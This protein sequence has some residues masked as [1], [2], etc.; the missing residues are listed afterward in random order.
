MRYTAS[1]D[2]GDLFRAKPRHSNLLGLVDDAIACFYAHVAP[3]FVVSVAT[4]RGAGAS[5]VILI[6]ESAACLA[7]SMSS[8][9]WA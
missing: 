6:D 4:L 8:W 3:G 5:P 1:G 2:E 9:A 7:L